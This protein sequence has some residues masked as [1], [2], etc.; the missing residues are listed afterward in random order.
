MKDG[1]C[2][3]DGRESTGQWLARPGSGACSIARLRVRRLSPLRMAITVRAGGLR[4]AL[5]AL[6]LAHLA[7]DAT[8]LR[9]PEPSR[10]RL[11]EWVSL[12]VIG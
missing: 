6:A 3:A 1:N 2:A 7:G 11:G 12:D 4:P 8:L 9:P 5:C 10:R